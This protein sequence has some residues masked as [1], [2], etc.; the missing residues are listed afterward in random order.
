MDYALNTGGEKLERR[1]TRS[2]CW[3]ITGERRIRCVFKK[4]EN[5][6]SSCAERK[7]PFGIPMRERF[8]KVGRKRFW[9]PPKK[10]KKEKNTAVMFKEKRMN[11]ILQSNNVIKTNWKQSMVS[12]V[13][14]EAS[15]I[16]ILLKKI[17]SV[18]AT[19]NSFPIPFMY[20]YIYI[21]DV[22][23]STHATLDVLSE[24]QIDYCSNV[25]GDRILSGQ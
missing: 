25:D 3:G 12:V 21:Y 10:K 14:V 2:R 5:K 17:Q 7:R 9:N 20:I 15:L 8:C 19:G 4:N 13:Y 24:C 16:V 11:Q 22:V 1:P 18:C 23:R 6:R